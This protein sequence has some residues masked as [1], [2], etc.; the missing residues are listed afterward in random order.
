MNI[1][2]PHKNTNVFVSCLLQV[3][4]DAGDGENGFNHP[5]SMTAQ[6]QDLANTSLIYRLDSR[7]YMYFF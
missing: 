3:G 2:I 4:F 7:E 1:H 6:V 5:Y